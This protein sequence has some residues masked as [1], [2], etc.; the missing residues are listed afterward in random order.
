[1]SIPT[2]ELLKTFDLYD[3]KR[4]GSIS[5]ADI[6]H[7][8][9]SCGLFF[10]E[11]DM[12]SLLREHFPTEDLIT[13]TAFNTFLQEQEKQKEK[14]FKAEDFST[15]EEL[16]LAFRAFD[17]HEAGA[18]T[19]E[20]V[21]CILTRMDEAIGVGAYHDVMAG[22]VVDDQGRT[23]LEQLARYILRPAKEY[24]LT[25]NQTLKELEK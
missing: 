9:R 17:S 13:R 21:L 11:S 16:T 15:V 19:P 24:K 4:V 7:V 23:E 20:E 8:L 6:P 5:R 10:T 22:I 18:L 12:A 1:M 2:E 14:A 3:Y 25:T